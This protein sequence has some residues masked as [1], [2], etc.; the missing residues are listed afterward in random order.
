VVR[1]TECLGFANPLEFNQKLTE[2][3]KTAKM[4]FDTIIVQLQNFGMRLLSGQFW[5][6]FSRFLTRSR[7]FVLDVVICVA[8]TFGLTLLIQDLSQK[9]V[10]ITKINT[11]F[12][13]ETSGFTSLTLEEVLISNVHKIEELAR[14]SMKSNRLGV[15]ADKVDF[16]VPGAD[17]T[18]GTIA[19]LIRDIFGLEEWKI[20]G[21]ITESK[22][23]LFIEL[24]LNEKIIYQSPAKG[25]DPLK[26]D[27][28][29]TDASAAIVRETEPFFY[30]SYVSDTDPHEAMR[31]IDEII[32]RLPESDENVIRAY[33]LRGIIQKNENDIDGAIMSY[34]EANYLA[35]KYGYRNFSVSY[36]NLALLYSDQ[37]E[38]EKSVNYYR[39]AIKADP[40]NPLIYND[41][42]VELEA[43]A[44][45]DGAIVKFH[46]AIGL[47]GNYAYAYGNLAGAL[48]MKGDYT[49][50]VE[51]Y[52]EAI[53]ADPKYKLA[54]LELADALMHEGRTDEAVRDYKALVNLDTSDGYSWYQLGAAL[55]SEGRLEE[56]CDALL[57]A[58]K[59][60]GVSPKVQA[61]I[62]QV[63]ML[64]Q[65]GK[66]A[67]NSKRMNCE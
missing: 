43:G 9:S 46:E 53:R 59:L 27:D 49:D 18:I 45:I 47:D 60:S 19:S 10:S 6:K 63:G 42:G 23:L 66:A 33:N 57:E 44:D 38:H 25:V 65:K 30:A 34:N 7:T 39:R 1:R 41:F 56:S 54:Y 11:P 61:E 35:E 4:I 67:G 17:V 24:R 58:R 29:L 62:K 26:L 3:L 22:N 36:R 28:A 15:S 13:L 32:A 48:A 31:I 51:S 21:D 5:R 20:S 55:E 50:S 64:L 40:N 37:G 8:I 16:A 2:Q 14:T 12:S 52:K